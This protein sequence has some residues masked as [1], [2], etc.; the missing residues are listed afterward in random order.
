MLYHSYLKYGLSTFTI[1]IP[2]VKVEF[3]LGGLLRLTEILW[4]TFCCSINT[5]ITLPCVKW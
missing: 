4:E 5:L 1:G 3:Y 2:T